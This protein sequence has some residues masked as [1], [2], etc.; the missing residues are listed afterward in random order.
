M[1][2]VCMHFS[3]TSPS[4]PSCLVL[5]KEKCHEMEAHVSDLNITIK[6]GKFVSY[7][8][9]ECDKFKFSFL[10]RLTPVPI[11]LVINQTILVIV[12]LLI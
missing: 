12:P 11:G 5:N 7:I 8:Y 2:D 10:S 3:R 1:F 4:N 9:D 6:D